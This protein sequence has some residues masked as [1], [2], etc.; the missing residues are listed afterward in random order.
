MQLKMKRQ[1]HFHL[2]NEIYF[3]IS[4]CFELILLSLLSRI[5]GSEFKIWKIPIKHG[6]SVFQISSFSQIFNLGIC[7]SRCLLVNAYLSILFQNSIAVL[8]LIT[9]RFWAKV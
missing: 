4:K 7:F 8:F 5:P 6:Q 3:S 9:C 1:Q 2:L